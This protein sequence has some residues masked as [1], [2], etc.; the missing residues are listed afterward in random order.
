MP[1]VLGFRLS[2]FHSSSDLSIGERKGQISRKSDLKMHS[3][4]TDNEV[5]TKAIK[6]T[7]DLLTDR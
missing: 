1:R 7:S 5:K 4:T 6:V 3:Q 2:V